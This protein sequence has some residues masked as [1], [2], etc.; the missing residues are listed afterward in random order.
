MSKSFGNYP[1]PRETIEKYG[2]DGVRVGSLL[3]SAAGND[4]LF[5]EDLMLQGRNFATKI[6]NAARYVFMN[7]EEQPVTKP[8]SPTHYSRADLWIH[9]CGNARDLS[10]GLD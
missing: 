4:L 9:L 6:W 5:D 3:S 1:D 7:C 8:T 2:A 10:D